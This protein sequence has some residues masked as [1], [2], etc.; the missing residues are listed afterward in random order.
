MSVHPCTLVRAKVLQKAPGSG[1]VGTGLYATV[2]KVAAQ[3]GV[4]GLYKGLDAQLIKTVLAS[5]FTLMIKE[6]SF[7][8]AMLLVYVTRLS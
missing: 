6:K 3:E 7:R 4:M 8:A 2:G 5:A 1:C